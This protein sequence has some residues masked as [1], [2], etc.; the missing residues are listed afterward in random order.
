MSSSIEITEKQA[1][2]IRNANKRWNFAVGAV[3]SGKSHI[4]IQYVIPQGILERKGKKG[5]NLILGASRENI[6]RNVLTPMRMIWGDT[7]IT[8]I[9]SR[10]ICR[11]F[12]EEVYCLG[13]NNVGAVAKLRGS[14]VKFCYCDEI[15]DIHKE[16]FEILKSRLSLP[17]SVCHA[18]ANPS[19]PT[20]YVKQFIDSAEN[21]IDIYCQTYTLYDNPFLPAEYIK[22]LENEYKGTVYFLR[23]ILGKW[24]KAEGLIYPMYEQALEKVDGEI[25]DY[26]VSIDYGTLNAFAA[27]LWVKI[28]DVWYA[29]REY[30]YS[31]RDKGKTKTD[32]EYG[33]D[34]EE[35]LADIIEKL[36]TGK[37]IETII[38][39]SAASFIALLRKK[40]WCKCRAGD[41]AVLDGIRETAS[42]IKQGLIKINPDCANWK[43]EASGYVWDENNVGEER[44]IK[45]ND[46]CLTGDTIVNTE[47]GA[48]PISELVGTSG[49]VWSY[50]TETGI[51]E[52]KPY[53]DCRLTQQQAEIYEIETIDGRFIHCTSEHPILT[54]RGYVLTKDL[55]ESDKIIDIT[56]STSYN[57]DKGGLHYDS[58]L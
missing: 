48:K 37:R 14:E 44:P 29:E 27:L 32:S 19:Y 24:A 34:L 13:A 15:C 4:A 26:C 8:S 31:G 11:I 23:Y 47:H 54:E 46:H 58:V 57:V 10:S 50:N 18:A 28:K 35:W 9:N 1:E 45:E 49:R 55:R 30:Y 16:V 17:Y 56:D 41:N 7:Y 21:G 38:D 42:A 3:R 51:A 53:H 39:P 25:Q 22:A 43:F 5:I 40:P 6:E 2:Y 36:P 20:H 33:K 52:L 12:G